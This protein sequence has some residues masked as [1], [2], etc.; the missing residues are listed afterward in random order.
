MGCVRECSSRQGLRLPLQGPV[1][2]FVQHVRAHSQFFDQLVTLVPAKFYLAPAEEEEEK[3]VR[4]QFARRLLAA[5]GCARPRVR[6]W[7][8]AVALTLAVQRF[9]HGAGEKGKAK[10][11]AKENSKKA[12]RLKARPA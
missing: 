6:G 1:E 9:K 7:V 10:L 2:S 3:T 8:C 11:K 5:S 12:K 4:A